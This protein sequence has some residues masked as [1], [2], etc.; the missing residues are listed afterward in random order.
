MTWCAARRWRSSGENPGLRADGRSR[1]E[2][3]YPPVRVQA[4][5]LGDGDQPQLLHRL[6][7]LQHRLSG[8]EQHRR[9]SARRRCCGTAQMHWITDRYLVQRRAGRAGRDLLPADALHA[10]RARALR[11]RLPGRG[12]RPRHRRPQRDGLQPLRRHPLLLQQLPVQGPAVQLLRLFARRSPAGDVRGTP[13]SR[14]GRA[15]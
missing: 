8:G 15:A 1:T 13:M 6:Q 11:G 5:R 14:S 4:E 3:L 10:L 7:R 2:S 12:D 9:S